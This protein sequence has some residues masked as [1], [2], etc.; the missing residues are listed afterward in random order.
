MMEK[1]LANAWQIRQAYF[2]NEIE[3]DF[4]AKTKAISVTGHL[5]QLKCAHCNGHYLESMIPLNRW[6]DQIG[7]DISSCLIS[8]GCELNG[9]V[10]LLRYLPVIKEIKNSSRKINLHVGLL[11]DDEIAQICQAADVVSFDFVGDTET[12]TEVYGHGKTVEDYTRVYLS[13]RKKVKVLPHICIGLRGGLISGEYRALELLAELGAEGIVFL[14]FTPTKG[15]RYADRQPP[16]IEDV[17]RV[18]Y[19]ARKKFPQIPIHLGCMRPIGK[20]RLVLDELALRCGINKIVKPTRKAVALANEL[21][22]EIN[23]GEECC[24][25]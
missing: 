3:F 1:L 16:D 17:V 5:C 4:P 23:Y 21:G 22:L 2:P 12:I 19:E 20:Y 9:K 6:A 7:E 24:V 15:T 18:L 8:G 14:V 11:D 13:L 10:P 25:L